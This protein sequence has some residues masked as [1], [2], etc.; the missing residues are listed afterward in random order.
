M[1]SVAVGKRWPWDDLRME[2]NSFVI[3]YETVDQTRHFWWFFKFD[4]TISTGYSGW[5]VY[6]IMAFSVKQHFATKYMSRLQVWSGAFSPLNR[7]GLPRQ[8]LWVEA[9]DLIDQNSG[10]WNVWKS[11]HNTQVMCLE[12]GIAIYCYRF[13]MI[14]L[15][16]FVGPKSSMSPGDTWK[17][18]CTS[19][20]D[21]S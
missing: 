20:C 18:W 9:H 13:L 16:H 4:F 3:R 15:H 12:N 11:F 21:C 2:R 14:M 5:M 7:L 10:G 17:G 8:S 1:N 19:Y 6:S